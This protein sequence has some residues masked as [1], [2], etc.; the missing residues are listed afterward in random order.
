MRIESLGLKIAKPKKKI[1]P[2]ISVH[3]IGDYNDADYIETNEKWY[4]DKNDK[5]SIKEIKEAIR[6]LK[7]NYDVILK[8]H[9]VR[10]PDV[11]D[12]DIN[13]E[14][15]ERFDVPFCV[16]DH[17]HTI[18]EIEL[19]YTNENGITYKVALND[20]DPFEYDYNEDED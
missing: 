15:F 13:E 20:E 1:I 9:F 19:S 18:E 3:I 2:Y 4:L 6:F 14:F 10:E 5:E 16:D 11:E 17:C 8:D 7:V 12:Q